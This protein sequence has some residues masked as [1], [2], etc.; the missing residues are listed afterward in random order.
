M[1]VTNV[2]QP[3]KTTTELVTNA[4][5]LAIRMA[6]VRAAQAEFSTFTQEQVDHIFK[7]ASIAANTGKNSIGKNGS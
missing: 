1:K 3:K 7:A 2:E 4:E 5:E 6:E